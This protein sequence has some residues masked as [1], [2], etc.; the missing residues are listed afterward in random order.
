MSSTKLSVLS[1]S[2]NNVRIIRQE[3]APALTSP[4]GIFLNENKP[5]GIINAV[6]CLHDSFTFICQYHFERSILIKY[7]LF[8]NRTSSYLRVPHREF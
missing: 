4:K 8:D 5:S 2:L 3:V 7:L 1:K 6:K